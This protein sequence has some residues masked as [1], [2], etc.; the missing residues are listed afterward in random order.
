MFFLLYDD[1]NNKLYYTLKDVEK[2]YIGVED[3]NSLYYRHKVF[4]L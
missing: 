1:I 3:I 2:H 4:T